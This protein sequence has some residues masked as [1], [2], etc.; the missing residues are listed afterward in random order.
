MLNR[1]QGAMADTFTDI[2]K[3]GISS[4]KDLTDRMV[5]VWLRMLEEMASAKLMENVFEPVMSGGSSWLSS[6][7]SFGAGLFS[8]GG[9]SGPQVVGIGGRANGGPVEPGSIYEVNERGPELLYTGGKQYLMMGET[10]GF[11][12][13]I[14]SSQAVNGSTTNNSLTISVPVTVEG[15]KKLGVDLQRNIEALVEEIIRRHT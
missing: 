15:S 8:G 4:W 2:R 9:V 11:V 5:D 1:F 6:A 3:A 12:S 14:Q 7:L 13:P 10:P